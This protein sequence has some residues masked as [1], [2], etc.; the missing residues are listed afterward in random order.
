[1]VQTTT[2]FLADRLDWILCYYTN[3]TCQLQIVQISNI[4]GWR[5]ERLVFPKQRLLFEATSEAVLEI[6]VS[7][8]TG[9]ALREQLPCT[10]LQVDEHTAAPRSLFD[11]A[12]N[13][14]R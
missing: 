10:R 14:E 3:P 11:G 12:D 6:Y 4:L 13:P 2:V 8:P 7:T 5:Y 1:M 9:V